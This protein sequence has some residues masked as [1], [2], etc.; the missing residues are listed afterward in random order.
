MLR[1]EVAPFGHA[2]YPVRADARLPIA[3]K[4]LLGDG[5]LDRLIHHQLRA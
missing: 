3:M 4:R 5:L 2:R 1:L